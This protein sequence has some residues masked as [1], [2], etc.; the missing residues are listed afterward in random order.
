MFLGGVEM[1]IKEAS[2]WGVDFGNVLIQNLD[3]EARKQVS[4]LFSCGRMCHPIDRV[5][6]LDVILVAHSC[7]VSGA[8][9]G[10]KTLIER[11]G[12]E[13]VWIVSCAKELERF[14]NRRLIA[15]HKIR[16]VTGLREDHIFF[17]DKREGK[18]GICRNLGIEAHIDDRGEVLSHLVNIVPNLIWFS[19]TERDVREWSTVL[20]TTTLRVNGWDELIPQL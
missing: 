17:V 12:A 9:E 19:P 20:P 11:R 1:N 16:E 4:A 6:E 15:V 8:L 3:Q 5:D 10:L 7:M 18:A 2:K 14:V 13:H